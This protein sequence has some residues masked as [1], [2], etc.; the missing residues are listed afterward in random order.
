MRTLSFAI[1][2]FVLIFLFAFMFAVLG[3]GEYTPSGSGEHPALT[4][5]LG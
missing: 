1:L 4:R 3:K 5:S 2:I